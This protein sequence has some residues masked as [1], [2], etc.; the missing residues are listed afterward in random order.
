MKWVF[1][2][3][4]CLALFCSSVTA[5]AL[6]VS[7]EGAVLIN[8]A[9][10]QMLWGKNPEKPLS[11]A[12]TTK[13]MT[14]LLL[15]ENADLSK[16]ITATEE[17]VTVEGSSMGLLP[18]DKVSYRALLY[19]MLLSSGN[20][21]ANTVALSLAGSAEK[22]S[23]LMNKKAAEIGMENTHFVTASGLDAAGHY[24]T[25]FDM[26][27]LA[28][29]A[30]EN[31]EFRAAAASKYATLEYGNPPYKRTLKNHNKLLWNYEGAIGVKTGYTKK[32]GRCLVSAAVRD[33]EYLIAVT[34]NAPSDW[35][36]HAAMLDYGFS[37]LS[38]RAL[39]GER[40]NLAVV[41]GERDSVLVESA[42]LVLAVSNE[43]YKALEKRV[44]L[45]Q[46]VYANVE[47][48]KAFGRVEYLI[49]DKVLASSPLVAA[50]DIKPAPND[51][52][53][54]KIFSNFKKLFKAMV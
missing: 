46:F 41:G 11:M 33:G 13:I 29:Y 2:V 47:K 12:S 50:N 16:V 51:G 23:T 18:N 49:G 52:A 35:S 32:S 8:G 3:I 48:G 44:I 5:S 45:P 9:T 42:P 28:R 34:L 10:G 54:Y 40:Y 20:D 30:M 6:S 36:D 37:L 19:G 1:S 43:E 26:A 25:A 15:C 14:A 27:K 39:N 22:F 31:P 38:Q 4:L 24:S 7:A 21:A 17:M 53:V